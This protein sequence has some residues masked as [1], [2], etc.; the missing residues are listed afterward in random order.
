VGKSLSAGGDVSAFIERWNGTAW[1]VTSSPQVGHASALNG[2]AIVS[3]SNAWAVGAYEGGPP[4]EDTALIEHWNGAAWKRVPSPHPGAISWLNAVA[5]IS[6]RNA[7]A[8]GGYADTAGGHDKTF[9]EHWNGREWKRALT[10]TVMI[11]L[12]A[13]TA[14]SWR[15]AWAVGNVRGEQ[16]R[17]VI[18]HWNGRGWKRVAYSHPAGGSLLS[19][20]AAASWRDVWAV[21]SAT[22][23]TSSGQALAEHWNGRNWK[24]VPTPDAGPGVLASVAAVS[25]RN[26]WAVGG[27]DGQGHSLIEHWNGTNWSGTSTPGL[28][29][30]S[31]VGSVAASS[32]SNVWAV[33]SYDNATNDFT[34]ALHCG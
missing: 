7:W 25:S 26:A 31:G 22:L 1:R 9:I 18:L 21:G 20:V 32:A 24:R 15:N 28:G 30:T 2:V 23:R 16:P 11:P 13:V 29:G 5:A 12:S 6:W 17:D 4:G 8:V 14:I 27:S 33:G 3:A 19:G 34:F 10:P